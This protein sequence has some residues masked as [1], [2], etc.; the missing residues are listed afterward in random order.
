[1]LYPYARSNNGFSKAISRNNLLVFFFVL[2]K[3]ILFCSYLLV[4]SLDSMVKST[5]ATKRYRIM[6]CLAVACRN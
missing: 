2:Q 3:M 6:D 5:E 4:I 1:M